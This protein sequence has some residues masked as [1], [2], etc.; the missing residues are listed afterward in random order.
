MLT[1]FYLITKVIC[2][3]ILSMYVLT[4]PVFIGFLGIEQA[5]LTGARLQKLY[6]N[7]NLYPLNNVYYST[8]TRA[9]ETFNHIAPALP[10]AHGELRACN[11]IREGAVCQPEPKSVAWTPSEEAFRNDGARVS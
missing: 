2:A 8:M 7:G 3:L 5:K 6:A 10:P 9:T 1:T 11:M 4:L